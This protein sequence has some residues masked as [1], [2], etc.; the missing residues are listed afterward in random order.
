MAAIGS[1]VVYLL[2]GI[3]WLPVESKNVVGACLHTF[4]LALFVLFATSEIRKM[5]VCRHR[6]FEIEDGDIRYFD[7]LEKP[8][9]VRPLSSI[10]GLKYRTYFGRKTEYTIAFHGPF[11]V[12][13][14]WAIEGREELIRLLEEGSGQ[15]FAYLHGEEPWKNPRDVLR[16]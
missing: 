6:R 15:K 7:R 5:I 8:M 1:A 16:G 4:M 10:V 14:G 13:F 3:L 11:S 2:G 12:E 9:I